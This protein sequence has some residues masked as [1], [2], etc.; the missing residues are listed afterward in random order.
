MKKILI[1]GSGGQLGSELKAIHSRYGQF[2]FIFTDRSNMDISHESCIQKIIDYRPDFII[3]TAAY[4]SVDKSE[5]D[6]DNAMLVNATAV[7]YLCQAANSLGAI[8]I[9]ISSDYVYHIKK[10]GPLVETDA[11]NPQSTYAISKKA[12]EI[13]VLRECNKG[14]II[15]TSW[16]YSYFGHNFVNTML[17]LAETK[18]ELNIVDDQY[19]SP[20]YAADLAQAILDIATFLSKQDDFKDWGVYNFSNEGIITWL[21]FAREIFA[22]NEKNIELT[23]TTTKEYNAPA[24]RPLWSV[25]SKQKIKST[26]GTHTRH[27][28]EALRECLK[29][30]PK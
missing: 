27:W 25:M 5:I 7:Q 6:Y 19:G 14:I 20:T 4:T 3:N 11:T 30:E 13:L 8:L 26:F 23:P 18:S 9:H 17:H 28:R 1:T 22:L 10:Y 24:K 29:I 16:L 21:G 15:R 12:G 2:E